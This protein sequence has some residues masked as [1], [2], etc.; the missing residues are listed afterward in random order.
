MVAYKQSVLPVSGTNF[1]LQPEIK[2]VLLFFPVFLFFSISQ[3]HIY[4]LDENTEKSR[5]QHHLQPEWQQRMPKC[6]LMASPP[7]KSLLTQ[8]HSIVQLYLR[9]QNRAGSSLK[10]KGKIPKGS[11]GFVLPKNIT[12]TGKC[13]GRSLPMLQLGDLGEAL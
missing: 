3:G 10:T 1:K 13:W 8:L 6:W 2:L 4:S 7:H 11:A 9:T 5:W 12:E